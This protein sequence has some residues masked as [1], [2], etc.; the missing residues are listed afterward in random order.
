ME[1]R[2]LVAELFLDTSYAIAR[3]SPPD[4]YHERAIALAQQIEGQKSGLVRTCAVVLEIGNAL[5]K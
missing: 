3:S 5:A 2:N 1:R 4:R